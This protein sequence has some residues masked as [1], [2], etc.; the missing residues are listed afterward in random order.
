ML[1]LDAEICFANNEENSGYG[2]NNDLDTV[3][4]IRLLNKLW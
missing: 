3:N 4:I 1:L 2:L